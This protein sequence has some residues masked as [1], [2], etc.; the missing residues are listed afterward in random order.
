MTRSLKL[1]VIMSS[2]IAP[3]TSAQ[4][5][6][7]TQQRE[8]KAE[9]SFNNQVV[10]QAADGFAHFVA[11][12]VATTPFP[13]AQGDTGT[14]TALASI[15][16]LVD[17]NA[18]SATGSLAAEGGLTITGDGPSPVFGEAAAVVVVSFEVLAPTAYIMTASPRPS[19]DPNDEFEIELSA[20]D[21]PVM[22]HI[23]ETMPPVS[24]NEAGL[25]G[26]GQYSV[27]YQVELTGGAAAADAS[28]SFNFSLVSPCGAADIGGAGGSIGWDRQLDNNDFIV[29]IDMFFTAAASADMGSAGGVPGGDGL[30]DN[31]DFIVFIDRF[32]A[33]SASCL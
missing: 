18:I 17:P 32:F 8:V 3:C 20:L 4:V 31:N 23:D 5:A 22:F 9:L 12:A 6:L 24:V 15:N 33:G 21:G 27:Q 2:F 16:C 28:Y 10:T 13:S 25:L 30:L 26:A 11:T 19:I 14:N 7:L 1:G 29:F